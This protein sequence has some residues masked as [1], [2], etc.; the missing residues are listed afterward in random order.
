MAEVV[1][2]VFDGAEGD[3]AE[4]VDFEDVLLLRRWGRSAILRRRGRGADVDVGFF[5]G[6]DAVAGA[7]EGALLHIGV[8]GEVVEA[9]VGEA[10]AVICEFGGV[11]C[12]SRF[13]EGG[14]CGDELLWW[15]EVEGEVTTFCVFGSG[16][17]VCFCEGR[18]RF[19]DTAARAKV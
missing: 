18:D 7:V 2:V 16:D 12:Q 8:E 3:A 4:A 10:V 17:E 5:A 15:R 11:E 6:A 9:A 14:R 13:L 19:V 1:A